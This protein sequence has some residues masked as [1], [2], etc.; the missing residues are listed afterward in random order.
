MPWRGTTPLKR[1]KRGVS[2]SFLLFK[3]TIFRIL[4]SRIQTMGKERAHR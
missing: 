3:L 1:R 4:G 2:S